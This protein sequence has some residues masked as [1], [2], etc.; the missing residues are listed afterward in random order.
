MLSDTGDPTGIAMTLGGYMKRVLLVLALV[1]VM[2][3]SVAPGALAEQG[4]RQNGY[5]YL[6]DSELGAY[7][8]PPSKKACEQARANDPM[9]LSECVK[10]SKIFR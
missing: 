4:K 3:A 10:E 6:Y 7:R 1:L 5:C 2:A 8:C 9:A